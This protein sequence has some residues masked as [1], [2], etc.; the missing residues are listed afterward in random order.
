MNNNK[1]TAMNT[2][3]V[4]TFRWLRVNDISLNLS[5]EYKDFPYSTDYLKTKLLGDDIVIQNRKD[6]IADIKNIEALI[7]EKLE[8]VP[9]QKDYEVN[10][11]L[12]KE[13]ET[14]YNA[15]IYVHVPKGRKVEDPIHLEYT[16]NH[17]HPSLVDHHL[18]V[19]EANAKIT[20]IVDYST[21]DTTSAY[22]NGIMKVVAK[23]GS[24]VTII[25]I[26]RM[27]DSSHHF[28]SNYAYVEDHASVNYIQ[29]E[30]G[31]KHSV[32]SF[33]S[34]IKEASEA[35][36]DSVYFGDG[37]RLID[38]NYKMN[39]LGRRSI[40]NI[41]TKGALKDKAIKTFRG[42]LDFKTGASR[43]EGC[44]EEYVILFDKEV[45]S[46]SIPL[47][48]C[49]E[50]DVKGQHAASAGKMDSEKLFYMMSRGFAREEAMKMIVEASFQPILGKV[51][52]ENLREIVG[53]EIHRR[54]MNEKL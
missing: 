27:N 19:A 32:T 44:E 43:S 50:D 54:L 2:L 35:T 12:R 8:A 46:N 51:P 1:T 47:L 33:R 53:K 25:K 13:C 49:G 3:P 17:D 48:L 39:H 42:T 45:T 15:G 28:D 6:S 34:D 7:K 37:D 14:A 22:H 16:L 24:Q 9:S 26:Q 31:G 10:E 36:I 20:I 40:S 30:L 5:Y 29:I 38:L 11:E 4:I 21:T 18:I 41:Q 23:E 52:D